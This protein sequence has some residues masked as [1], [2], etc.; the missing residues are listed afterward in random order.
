M[1]RAIIE[2]NEGGSQGGYLEGDL[3][4]CRQKSENKNLESKS[5]KIGSGFY[6]A[7]IP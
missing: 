6:S 4:H 7:N 2:A 5:L 3:V 1:R